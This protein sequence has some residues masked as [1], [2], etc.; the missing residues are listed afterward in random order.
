MGRFIA[1]CEKP[2]IT[3]EEFREAFDRVK[4]WRIDRRTW[5]VKAYCDLSTG[6][7]VA[8]CEAPEKARFEE[9]LKNTGWRMDTIYQVN[10]ILEAGSIWPV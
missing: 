10:L 3:E 6:K 1:V 7:L 8:E 9:W 4:K 5:I 2:G